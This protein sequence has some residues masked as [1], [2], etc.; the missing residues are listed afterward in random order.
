VDFVDLKLL[1]YL[2]W[3]LAP[4]EKGIGTFQP[5]S[6]KHYTIFFFWVCDDY[7]DHIHLMIA[8]SPLFG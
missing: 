7:T 5:F 2:S 6:T 3:L 1:K 8:V 4:L